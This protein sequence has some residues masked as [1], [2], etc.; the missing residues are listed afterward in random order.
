MCLS[1]SKARKNGDKTKNIEHSKE[2][3]PLKS[4]F[5]KD[6]EEIHLTDPFA[7]DPFAGWDCFDPWTPE[8]KGVLFHM[9]DVSTPTWPIPERKGKYKYRYGSKRIR[10]W[11][12]KNKRNKITECERG[13]CNDNPN[14]KKNNCNKTNDCARTNLFE[15]SKPRAI[16]Q[17]SKEDDDGMSNSSRSS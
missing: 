16:D 14:S 7:A 8:P 17:A 9:P 5:K 2:K 10:Q 6:Q 3:K 4:A 12:K 15:D 1:M 13:H 11:R